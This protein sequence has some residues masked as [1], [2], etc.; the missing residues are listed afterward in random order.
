MWVSDSFDQREA[1][2]SSDR[3]GGDRTQGWS[4]EWECSWGGEPRSCI[5]SCVVSGNVDALVDERAGVVDT[6]VVL[7]AGAEEPDLPSVVLETID[8]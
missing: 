7:T 1:R 5:V 3:E 8:D 6:R 4:R 2:P